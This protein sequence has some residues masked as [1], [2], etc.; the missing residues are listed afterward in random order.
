MAFTETQKVQI[1]AYLGYPDVFQDG[2]TRLES[3]FDVLGARAEAQAQAESIMADIVT[4]ATSVAS[5]LTKA[6]IK[7][8]DE[9][10]FFDEQAGNVFDES[11]RVGRMHIGR[12]STLFGVPI[13]GDYF[14]TKGYAGSIINNTNRLSAVAHGA[15]GVIPM[16]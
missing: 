15:G 5:A 16:G 7:K 11:R 4:A 3:V 1:R 2:N 9:I 6:G 14:G 10:E 8:V 13:A 12:L